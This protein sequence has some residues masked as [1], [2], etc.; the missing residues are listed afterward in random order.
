MTRLRRPELRMRRALALTFLGRADEAEEE[1]RHAHV[2]CSDPVTAGRYARFRSVSLRVLNRPRD[3]VE[4]LERSWPAQ[5]LAGDPRYADTVGELGR[6]LLAAGRPWEADTYLARALEGSRRDIGRCV[7]GSSRSLVHLFMGCF[8]DA[9]DGFLAA[10]AD[11]EALGLVTTSLGSRGALAVSYW[12]SGRPAEALAAA[13]RLIEDADR[14]GFAEDA[15]AGRVLQAH[16]MVALGDAG[17]AEASA[18]AAFEALPSRDHRRACEVW[19]TR[20][21]V[22]WAL[23]RRDDARAFALEA[24]DVPE[25]LGWEWTLA[26]QALELA[27]YGLHDACEAKLM[28]LE[29]AHNPW[30]YSVTTAH[31]ARAEVARARGEDP[32][33]WLQPCDEGL[34]GMQW[35]SQDAP[36]LRVRRSFA[37]S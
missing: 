9:V 27:R 8:D 12:L 22:C 23:G 11:Q 18:L 15:V 30:R 14:V 28:R 32:S 25:T 37:S 4:V 5:E 2:R 21:A 29:D 31:L 17:G 16:V 10:L 1:L 20:A 33:P 13:E 34:R 26:D 36:L 3:A 24:P 35:G 7:Y 6:C 19:M